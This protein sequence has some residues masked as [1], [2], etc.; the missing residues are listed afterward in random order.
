MS[1]KENLSSNE[2]IKVQCYRKQAHPRNSTEGQGWEET[3]VN[4]TLNVFDNGEARTPTLV[5]QCMW[6]GTQVAPTLTARNAGGAQRMPDKENFNAVIT[7]RYTLLENLPADSRVKI[8]EDN[9]CQTLSG[10][11]GTGGGNVPMVMEENNVHILNPSDSQGN[12]IADSDGVYPTLRGCGGAGYQQGYLKTKENAVVR[13]LTTT[14]CTRLQGF[15]DG[16][17]DI[18]EWYDSKGKKHKDSDAPKYKAIGN[19]IALPFRQWLMNRIAEQ[20][21]K[22]GVEQ[23]TMGSLFSGIGSFELCSLRAG[24]EPIWNSEIEDF[25]IEVTKKHFG[26]EELGIQGDVEKYL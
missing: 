19:S 22:D 15:P 12:Q 25:C 8:C 10:R 17:L 18:G 1:M 5:V 11:M 14:E 9:I 6:D 2:P 7:T 24:I 21:K 4:D 23:P 13:R 3:T 16:W 26:D 20:I